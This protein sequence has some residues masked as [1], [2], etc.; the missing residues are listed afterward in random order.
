MSTTTT[1][2][3]QIPTLNETDTINLVT[4]INKMMNTIDNA[5]YDISSK[6]NPELT[7]LKTTVATLQT[8]VS[9]LQTA[10]TSLQN[11][12]KTYKKISTYGDLSKYGAITIKEN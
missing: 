8:T 10:L 1:T 3:Y 7:Q 9:G 12:I 6:E 5:M 2:H 4:D 11:T